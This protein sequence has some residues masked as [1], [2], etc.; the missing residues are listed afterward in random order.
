[1][2]TH[3][4]YRETHEFLSM[5]HRQVKAAGRRVA[6][7]DPGELQ[8]LLRIKDDLDKAIATSIA[9]LRNSGAT[10][11]DIGAATRTSRQAA[12]QKWGPNG[13]GGRHA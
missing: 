3:S 11:D 7:G 4:R 2:T 12:H 8:Q 1:M 13:T 9:G 5:L 6:Q 10:W